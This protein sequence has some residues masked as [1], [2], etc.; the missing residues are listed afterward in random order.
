[1]AEISRLSR[2]PKTADYFLGGAVPDK[3]ATTGHF[4]SV[5]ASSGG[6]FLA[7]PIYMPFDY[8]PA[9]DTCVRI[10][11]F[12]VSVTSGAIRLDAEFERLA[13]GGNPFTSDNFGTKKSV[14]TTVNGTIATLKIAEITLTNADMQTLA[15][16]EWGRLR[17]TRDTA[18]AGDT[19]VGDALFYGFSMG[20]DDS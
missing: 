9:K 4:V 7:W 6:P 15:E 13:E 8:K 11:W 10:G 3:T 14:T 16:N 18:H 12:S 19:L 17:L 2:G 1:M 20:Q 5:L